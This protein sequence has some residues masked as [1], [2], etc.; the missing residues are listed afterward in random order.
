[1]KLQT[2]NNLKNCTLEA[3]IVNESKLM[4]C[5]IVLCLF[6]FICGCNSKKPHRAPEQQDATSTETWP[7]QID[8]DGNRLTYYQPQIDTWTD[9]RKLSGRVAVVLTAAGGH[10]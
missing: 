7:R 8:K 3:Q 9:Y 10:G 6:A 4:R 5:L 2:T 1:M